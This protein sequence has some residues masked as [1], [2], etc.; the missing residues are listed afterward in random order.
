MRSH[1][2]RGSVPTR[3]R[4]VRQDPFFAWALS[5][6]LFAGAAAPLEAKTMARTFQNPI[7]TGF[8]PDPSFCR[9]GDDFYLTNSTFEFFPGLPIYHS[10]DLV[11]WE[12]V[13]NALVRP[14]QLPLKG[15]SDSGGLYA[16]TLR[17][18]KGTF[19]LICDNVSGGGNFIVTARDPAGPWSDPV[20]LG[21]Y[22]IDGSLFFD[23]DGRIYYH[24][25]GADNGNGISQGELDP[26]SLKLKGPLRKIW[27]YPGEW[28]EGPHLYKAQGNYYLISATGGTETHHQE[29]VARSES[30]W[31]PF[32][33][34]PH[35]PLLTERD[36]PRS[37]I[38]CAGHADLVEAP[39]GSWWAVFLGTRPYQGMSVLGRETFLAPVHWTKD[40]WPVVGND[41]HVALRM[42][43]P[44]LKPFPVKAN[45]PRTLFTQGSKGLGPEWLHIRN[46]D[47][48]DVSLEERPGYLRLHAA[49]D[50]LDSR[51]EAPAFVG[52]RQPALRFTARTALEFAPRQ[53][54]EE[55]GLCVRADE[56]NHYEIGVGRLGGQ[57]QLFVRNRI[58]NRDHWIAQR[59]LA[60]DKVQLEISGNEAK[61]R[62][63][64]SIDGKTWK[65][66]AVSPSADL[67][68]EKAGGF[69][70]TVLGL[71]ATSHGRS[72]EAYADF[73]WF[74]LTPDSV[75][76]IGAVTRRPA[77]TPLTPTDH[78]R[79]LTDREDYRDRAGNLW[80]WDLGYSGG[81]TSR[82]WGGIAGT[83]EA[84][85]FQHE[86][87]G[88]E[89]SYTLPV[90]PGKYRVRLKFAETSVREKGKR[91]FDLSINGRKVLTGFDILEEAGGS[92]RALEKSFDDVSPNQEGE[93]TLGFAASAGEAKVCALEIERR[94]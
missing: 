3:D 24:R 5:A 9:V 79:I 57:V 94:P 85:L 32:V 55:A 93:I 22:G 48:K 31:G 20:W 74:E 12:Q 40:G 87:Q 58:K 81:E 82:S 10:R 38:Q 33:S 60:S 43:A 21:D 17:Y 88:R 25:A 63:A 7:L 71:Y 8:H 76:A 51:W 80:S 28:N 19:Y 44:R 62:F 27:E 77:P 35:N 92:D 34:S 36:E 78:W 15:A 65:T 59:P 49:K 39:D 68:R 45:P 13:G 70:G 54:G 6:L 26:S 1:K 52:V 14:G 66:L 83:R 86:R 37:P 53:D 90:P 69:T 18:W 47:P 41:H 23:D 16:P 73:G 61:Y 2:S 75:P 89:F 29:V 91:V 64:W 11:H 84:E 56:G 50:G 42:A 72:S 4:K 46:G 30:P 67:S